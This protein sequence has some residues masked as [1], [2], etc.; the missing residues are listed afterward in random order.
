MLYQLT[1]TAAQ[2]CMPVPVPAAAPDG[3]LDLLDHW[4]TLVGATAGG[5]LGVAGAWIVAG[6]ARSC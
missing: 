5:L 1:A 4:Q 3:F 6:S 2:T